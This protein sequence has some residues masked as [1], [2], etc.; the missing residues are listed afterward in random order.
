MKYM[1]KLT[2]SAVAFLTLLSCSSMSNVADESIETGNSQLFYADQQTINLALLATLQSVNINIKE[3][4]YTEKGFRVLFTKSISAFSWGEVGRALVIKVDN[5]TSRIFIHSL[6]RDRL[7][8]TGADTSDLSSVIF[9][10]VNEIIE[11]Q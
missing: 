7:Q 11:Q 3:S 5:N 2:T 10:G 8:I 1:I 6:N 9:E 4:R